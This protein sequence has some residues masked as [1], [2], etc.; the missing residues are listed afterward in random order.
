MSEED[1]REAAQFIIDRFY[2]NCERDGMPLSRVSQRQNP[3]LQSASGRQ[4]VSLPTFAKQD[5]LDR[6]AA[7]YENALSNREY[8]RLAELAKAR[9]DLAAQKEKEL[10]EAKYFAIQRQLEDIDVDPLVGRV[11]R[12]IQKL[13]KLCLQIQREEKELD[14]DRTALKRLSCKISDI[15]N[16]QI[17]EEKMAKIAEVVPELEEGDLS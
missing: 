7:A 5:E 6:A 3:Q 8:G 15:V 12:R 1:K 14:L 10:E 11:K 16:R 13:E 17:R 4:P 9:D 2:E